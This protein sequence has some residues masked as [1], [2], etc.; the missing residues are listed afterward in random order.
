MYLLTT[1]STV[2]FAS[3]VCKTD[4]DEL[5]SQLLSN[6]PSVKMSQEV[7]KG[8]KERVDSAYWG[9]FPTP[10][11]DVSGKD[12]DRHT[13]V[14]RLDQPI[15]TGGKLT[16]KYDMATSKEKEN[17]YELEENSY[18]LIESYLNI[19]ESYLQSKSNIIELQ[20]G[21]DNLSKFSEMLDRRMEVG[22]SSTSDKDLL[23]A[24]IEQVSSD[25]MLAKNKYKVAT[26]QLELILDRKINCDI[27]FRD[28]TTTQN[29]DIEESIKKLLEFHPS[30]KKTSAQI[31]T[32]KFEQDSTEASIMPNLNLRVERR[33][34]DLYSDNYDKSN[35]QNI[36]YLAFTATTRAGLSSISDIAAA[37]IIDSLLSDYNNYE[38]A[39]NRINI[40]KRSVDSAQNVL[41]SYTRLFLAGKRQWL[42]LVNASREVMQYKIELS[43]LYVTKS[44]LSYKL[45]LKNGQIDLL[46]GEIK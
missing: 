43:N 31:E 16:S 14:A 6:H 25:K 28:I 37:K 29:S 44:I 30:L 34:G 39:K 36:V 19:L 33:E 8:A 46:T 22:V 1:V 9:F 11:V 32:S 7:I 35:D 15:W 12:S 23:S 26:L 5:L 40:L 2:S 3:E 20:E 42:D 21:A 10:S 4:S 24:R 13:A 17:V 18:K 27:D 45:A 41:D 38:I